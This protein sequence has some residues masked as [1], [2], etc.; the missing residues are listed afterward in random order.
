MLQIHEDFPD[1]I[2]SLQYLEALCKDLGRPA[3]EYSKKLDKLRR[4]IPVQQQVCSIGYNNFH[5]CIAHRRILRYSGNKPTG[6]TSCRTI[7]SPDTIR[8]TQA[9]AKR[10]PE[11][12]DTAVSA[13][14][15]SDTRA[16]LGCIGRL[17]TQSSVPE[18]CTCCKYATEEGCLRLFIINLFNNPFLFVFITFYDCRLLLQM[19]TKMT[20]PI[21]TLVICLDKNPETIIA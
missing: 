18:K 11:F 2:E 12:P 3:E 13:A 10:A 19:T 4:S 15:A 5:S 7:S 6:D 1:N 20:S 17:T 9:G 21:L 14:T 16:V 8:T